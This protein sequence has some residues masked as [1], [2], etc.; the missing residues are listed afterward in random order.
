MSWSKPG[1]PWGLTVL[2]ALAATAL[3]TL[4]VRR[5]AAVWHTLAGEDTDTGP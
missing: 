2:A 4:A 3:L 1:R 5:R